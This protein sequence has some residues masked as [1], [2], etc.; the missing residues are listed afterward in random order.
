MLLTGTLGSGRW[1]EDEEIL[2]WFGDWELLQPGL[3]SILEWRP[4][5]PGP[6]WRDEVYH[7]LLRRRRQ[8]RQGSGSLSGQAPR[9]PG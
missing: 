5:T 6:I 8:E 2:A 7:K 3:V 4:D 9:L 1:R